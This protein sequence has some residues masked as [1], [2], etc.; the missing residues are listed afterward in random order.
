[1]CEA[2]DLRVHGEPLVPLYQCRG[3][4]PTEVLEVGDPE[5]PQVGD[6]SVSGNAFARAAHSPVCG[7]HHK[8][9][10]G[11]TNLLRREMIIRK[12]RQ[13]QAQ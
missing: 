5:A 11:R 7:A 13:T 12:L 10:S 6:V 9:L 8:D 4:L 2:E 3:F 1:M